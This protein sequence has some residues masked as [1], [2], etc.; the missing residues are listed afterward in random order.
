MENVNITSIEE[1]CKKAS[2]K[3]VELPGWDGETVHFK[4]K[5]P[6]MLG[7]ASQGL[8]PNSL[9]AAAQKVFTQSVDSTVTLQ[10]IS[11]VMQVIAKAA[12]VSPTY[13]ELKSNNIDLTDEQLTAIFA[14]TQEGLNGLE[15]FRTNGANS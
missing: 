10:D 6:S 12:M 11:K 5:R 2:P 8:I 1:L 4:L 14:Y 7:L 15:Q 3:V 9:L 13:D